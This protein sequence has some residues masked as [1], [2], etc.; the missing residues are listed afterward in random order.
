MARKFL[1]IV[2][3]MVWKPFFGS[4][5]TPDK[6]MFSNKIFNLQFLY[7]YHRPAG[8]YAKTYGNYSGVG[9]GGM[10]KTKKNWTFSGEAN[11]LFGTDILATD[12]L[13][14]LVTS[15]GYISSTSGNPGNYIVNMRGYSFYLQGGR[16]FGWNKKNMNSG[17]LV[18]GGV[19]FLQHKIGFILKENNMPQLNENYARGYDRLS[20]GIS[21]NQ[22]IGYNHQSIN[23]LI[24]FYVGVEFMQAQTVNR[25]GFNY[26]EM[27]FDKGSKF[28]QSVSFR[29]GWMIPIYLNT[30]DENEFQFK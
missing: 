11:F 7:N 28:D 24:N 25:R 14:Q 22:F 2:L 3:F 10:L 19:G 1:I 18:K 5:Q 20:N 26:H 9:F 23:R 13:N 21:T 17:I 29:F 6:Y 30:R 4:A 12:I 27:E 16:V 8:D 15:G